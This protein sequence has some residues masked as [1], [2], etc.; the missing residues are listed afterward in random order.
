LYFS[1]FGVIIGAFFVVNAY[2]MLRS[3]NS[4]YTAIILLVGLFF[5]TSG[6][7][8]V[9]SIVF[10]SFI[11]YRGNIKDNSYITNY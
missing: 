3:F 2:K 7:S 4:F 1:K 9:D 8:L 11:F 10:S 6:I 5:T